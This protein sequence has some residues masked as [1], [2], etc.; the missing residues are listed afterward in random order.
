MF[1]YK[2]LLVQKPASSQQREYFLFA[3]FACHERVEHGALMLRYFVP[4]LLEVYSDWHGR[5]VLPFEKTSVFS[6][7]DVGLM[8]L[9]L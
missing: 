6:V 8:T 2:L 5:D 3:H 9:S 4:M 7:Q 1:Y